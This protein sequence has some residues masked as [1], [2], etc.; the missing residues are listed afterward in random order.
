MGHLSYLHSNRAIAS[1]YYT[2]MHVVIM[3][4]LGIFKMQIAA[5]S[6]TVLP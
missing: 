2:Y 4:S 6:Q 1:S 5:P 3:P